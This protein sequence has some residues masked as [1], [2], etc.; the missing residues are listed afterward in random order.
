MDYI[1]DVK[2]T[3]EEELNRAGF[4]V[5]GEMGAHIFM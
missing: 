1:A 2:A 4:V 5:R 3:L